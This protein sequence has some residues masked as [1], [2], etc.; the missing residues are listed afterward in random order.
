MKNEPYDIF[1]RYAMLNCET[2]IVLKWPLMPK[3]NY[4]NKHEAHQSTVVELLCQVVPGWGKPLA[5]TT[6]ERTDIN[7]YISGLFLIKIDARIC[8]LNLNYTRIESNN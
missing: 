5:V 7:L 1:E 8:H 3:Y 4:Y 6:P 2:I